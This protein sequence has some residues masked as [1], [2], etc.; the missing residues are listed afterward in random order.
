M[1]WFRFDSDWYENNANK[2]TTLLIKPVSVSYE[3]NGACN[4]ASQPTATPPSIQ[5]IHTQ[6][7]A[8]RQDELARSQSSFME[9]TNPHAR[10]IHYKKQPQKSHWGIFIC[11]TSS[12]S[13]TQIQTI[14]KQ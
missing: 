12:Q 14:Y 3:H 11:C 8:Q 5:P 13:S 10:G 9:H 7:A 6:S 2:F 1:S 4:K